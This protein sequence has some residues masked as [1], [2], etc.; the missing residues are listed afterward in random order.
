MTCDH[1]RELLSAELDGELSADEAVDLADHLAG[2]TG[3]RAYRDELNGAEPLRE[4][5]RQSMSL[6]AA[7]ELA[8]IPEPKLALAGSLR[9]VS[10]LRWVLFIIGGTLVVLN[11]SNLVFDVDAVDRHLTRH[12]GVFGTALGIGMLSVAAKPQRALGLVTLTSTIAVLMA[13]V[14]IA[15]VAGGQRTML[16]EA[17]HLLEFG[18]LICLWVISGGVSRAKR[19][20]STRRAPLPRSGLRRSTVTHDL[21]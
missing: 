2:C 21:R 7:E 19:F 8:S 11:V 5:T 17:I 3:C 15:D 1:S 20:A 14:A 13:V 16:A 4:L 10:A 18:G 12:D 6:H 9:T